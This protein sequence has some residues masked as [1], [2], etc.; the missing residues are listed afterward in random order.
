MGD[1][2]GLEITRPKFQANVT[3]KNAKVL[4]KLLNSE[5]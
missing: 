3:C 1:G 4:Q 2:L 5:N